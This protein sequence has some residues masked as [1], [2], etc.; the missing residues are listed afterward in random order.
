[1]KDI[2]SILSDVV[3]DGTAA[4]DYIAETITF[5]EI[6]TRL[7]SSIG[8]AHLISPSTSLLSYFFF[9]TKNQIS[10]RSTIIG[11]VITTLGVFFVLSF[12]WLWYILTNRLVPDPYLDEVFHI[13]QAQVYCDGD[14]QHW[15]D[16]ITTPPGLYLFSVAYSKYRDVICTVS[17][18]RYHNL[19]IIPWIMFIASQCR[20]LIEARQAE[21]RLNKPVV[22][23]APQN[24]FSL[25][26]AHTGVN[27]A[28]FPVVFF[29]SALYYTDVLST[30][31]VLLAY[32]NH[33]LRVQA[34]SSPSLL[35][36]IWTVI[37][38]VLA[39]FMRQTN[40]FWVVI[41]MGGLEAVH[42][43]RQIKP[44]AQVHDPPLDES[45]PDDWFFFFLSAAKTALANNSN[46][47]KL[48]RQIW[49]HLTVLFLFIGFVF[50]NGGV[51]LGDKSNHVATLHLSQLNYLF[52]LFAFFS[53]PL[54]LPSLLR[55]VRD[56][57]SFFS[58][59]RNQQVTAPDY[60]YTLLTTIASL[61]V[62]QFNTLVHPFTLAD[63][64]HY[65]FYVF[66]YT[67]L[68]S[69]AVR[70]ALVVPYT[71][72]RWLVWDSLISSPTHILEDE[73]LA[74]KQRV[75]VQHK[76]EESKKEE[77]EEKEE[78][79]EFSGPQTQTETSTV[80]LLFVSTGLSLVT[81]PLVEPRYFILP[82]VFWRL[83]VPANKETFVFG[84]K[85]NLDARLVLETAWFAV[86]NLVTMYIFLFEPYVWVGQRGKALDGGR[87][88]RFMW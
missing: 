68:R 56:P 28:L 20:K 18:L 34:G 13:P 39:L 75:L 35:R 53:F 50:N 46:P 66:R 42:V 5:Q 10:L 87:L 72:C 62:V 24:P 23:G 2:H 74:V 64:R 69:N 14:F 16:K 1:M 38:G 58:G 32:L 59:R 51:V 33:L 88:Q 11:H 55:L 82:W 76:K 21:R 67:I 29:F 44:A 12:S 63:N 8:L 86:V 71:I 17:N 61:A 15:D 60:Y 4:Y 79:Q 41:Y 57:P 70:L 80:L 36:D 3:I 22:L 85:W 43:L 19:V 77:E 78:Q 7:V 30:F 27:I 31:V 48:L 37:I 47:L 25:Y 54:L 65:M 49:P 84:T 73:S 81:A 45:G 9:P 83:L 52:P 26:A 40:I 6:V